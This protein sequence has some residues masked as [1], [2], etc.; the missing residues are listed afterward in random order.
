MTIILWMIY[1]SKL[2]LLVHAP[3]ISH[4]C[5]TRQKTT[6]IFS[7]FMVYVHSTSENTFFTPSLQPSSIQQ[8]VCVKLSIIID[9][10]LLFRTLGIVQMYCS[11]C[12]YCPFNFFY[13]NTHLFHL[14]Y[15]EKGI[16]YRSPHLQMNKN[17]MTLSNSEICHKSSEHPYYKGLWNMVT[18]PPRLIYSRHEAL[19][20]CWF[21]VFWAVAFNPF[22]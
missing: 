2:G 9:I 19:N 10:L 20:Q 5:K 4:T 16:W 18:L 15:F 8:R 1:R 12:R 13:G 21:I 14:V 3:D 17:D 22:Y 11:T 7:I 6:E